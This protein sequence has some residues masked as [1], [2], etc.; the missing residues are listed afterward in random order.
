MN[1]TRRNGIDW[2][3]LVLGILFVLTALISFQDPAGN[4]IAIVMVFAFFAIIK[5]I[6]EI[7]VRNRL[8]ELT[9]YKAYGPIILGV[10]DIIIGIYLF[11]NLNI[12]IAVLPFV[13][14]IWFIADSV[15][16]LF[17][18]DLAKSV[19]TG[20]FWFTLIINV[21]GIILG[22]MLLMDPL[23]SALTLSFLVGFYFMLYGITHI[24][25]AFR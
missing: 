20:Y 9:G 21:L 3:S 14:A 1:E 13:F 10:I 22:F 7:F 16:G 4:L 19:S 17:A 2:G 6:F 15:F 18:L 23:T 12:G 8:K 25:Y 11:F 5:G 24:V